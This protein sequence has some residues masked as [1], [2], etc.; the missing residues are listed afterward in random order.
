MHSRWG[1]RPD[2]TIASAGSLHLPRHPQAVEEQEKA[3]W[4]SFVKTFD[5]ASRAGDMEQV[6]SLPAGPYYLLCACLDGAAGAA[7]GPVLLQ[8]LKQ[9]PVM[10]ELH[11]ELVGEAKEVSSELFWTR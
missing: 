7:P 2:A 4:T 5:L 1:R 6:R 9:N 10:S 11:G 8:L 3:A